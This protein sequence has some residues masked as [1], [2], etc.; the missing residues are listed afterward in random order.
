MPSTPIL[1]I[2][3]VQ[4]LGIVPYKCKDIWQLSFLLSENKESSVVYLNSYKDMQLYHTNS[5]HHQ[6]VFKCRASSGG[7]CPP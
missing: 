6:H 4:K 7:L 5:I 3:V 1:F 2:F